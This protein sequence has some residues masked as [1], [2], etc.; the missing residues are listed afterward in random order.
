MI[1][2]APLILTGL[3]LA[4]PVMTWYAY[5]TR[6]N[7]PAKAWPRVLAGCSIAAWFGQALRYAILA[8]A[9]NPLEARQAT[10]LSAPLGWL[11]WLA[12]LLGLAAYIIMQCQR[13]RS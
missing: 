12:T 3:L 13:R 1:L 11:V 6:R 4:L 10:Q 5:K 7:Q 9:G 8:T 2:L